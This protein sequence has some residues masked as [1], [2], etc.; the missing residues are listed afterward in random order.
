MNLSIE[1][2]SASND[3]I[4]QFAQRALSDNVFLPYQNAMNW[5]KVC[6]AKEQH[7]GHIYVLAYRPT[8]FNEYY[9]PVI[10]SCRL[11]GDVTDRFISSPN[12]HFMSTHPGQYSAVLELSVE[13]FCERVLALHAAVNHI[14]LAVTRAT[15]T[16][17]HLTKSHP[18]LLFDEQQVFNELL[19]TLMMKGTYQ[20]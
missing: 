15:V 2:L 18:F 9:H 19:D 7:D 11:L 13:E 17:K 12:L 6:E 14:L 16:L 8:S 5:K 1:G 4:N 20:S 3:I 10:S